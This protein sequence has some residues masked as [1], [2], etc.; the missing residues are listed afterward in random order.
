M[1]GQ[2]PIYYN[3]KNTGRPPRAETTL[4][5]DDIEVGAEQTSFGMTA[6][7][8]DA[9]FEPRFPFGFGLTYTAFA[10]SAVHID[11][12]RMGF[13]DQLNVS[14]DVINT[15]SRAGIETVQL[16]IRDHAASVTRPVKELK[17]YKR[18]ELEAGDL[19]ERCKGFIH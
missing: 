17:A 9:G 5:I 8:L 4:L 18:V 7:H 13:E 11:K 6:F 3:H 2:T 19:I 15:G 16:Y 12:E 1:V 14:V 10:Y